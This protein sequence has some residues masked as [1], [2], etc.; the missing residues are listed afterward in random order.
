ML[1]ELHVIDTCMYSMFNKCTLI[2]LILGISDERTQRRLFSVLCSQSVPVCFHVFLAVD[3]R[4]ECFLTVRAHEWS[5]FTM[6]RHVS[7]QTSIC[8]KCVLTHA[9]LVGLHTCMCAHMCLQ[10]TT[11]HK[12][13]EALTTLVRLLSCG[14]NK[15]I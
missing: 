13:T 1:F 14:N 5:H 3:G 10:N 9:T 2:A 15:F 6:C 4:F 8:G 7:L 11:R 12:G